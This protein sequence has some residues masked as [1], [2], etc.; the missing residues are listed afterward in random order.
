MF[1]LDAGL[2]ATLGLL[3]LTLAIVGVYGVVSY[4]TN[5]RTHEIG[6]RLALGVRPM[7]VLIM[8]FRKE[9]LIVGVGI[10]VGLVL[11]AAIGRLAGNFLVG[12]A[13][14]DPITYIGASLLLA[15]VAL[16]ACYVPARRAMRVDPVVALRYE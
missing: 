2:A 9:L 3:G 5:Q 14:T 8:I 7:Q 11:A 12:V 16:F 1:K 13:P 6:I 15:V 4:T 10:V